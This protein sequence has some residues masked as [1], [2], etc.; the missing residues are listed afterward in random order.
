MYVQLYFGRSS[1]QLNTD[2]RFKGNITCK[3]SKG[4]R[5]LLLFRI[6]HEHLTKFVT[7]TFA[8]RLQGQKKTVTH[9]AF[10]NYLGHKFCL[11]SLDWDK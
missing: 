3:S 9:K 7:I 4:L 6:K 11:Y 2:K 5:G 8:E 10:S 1:A